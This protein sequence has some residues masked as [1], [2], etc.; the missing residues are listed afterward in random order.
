MART[1]TDLEKTMTPEELDQFSIQVSTIYATSELR[2]SRSY[3][4]K[5]YDITSDC[6][7]WLLDRSVI[8]NLVPDK[9]VDKMRKKASINSNRKSQEMSGEGTVQTEVHYARLIGERKWFIFLR[10]ISVEKKIEI[11]TYFAEHPEVSKEECAEKF[12][13]PRAKTMV[14]DKILE[15]TLMQNLVDDELYQ[16]VRKRSLGSNPS[17]YAINYFAALKRKRNKNKKTAS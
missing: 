7:Y 15:D 10:G 11:T 13:I 16:K 17:K 9:I 3:F 6:F 14:I 1:K 8:R 2:F 12:G 4:I 5:V